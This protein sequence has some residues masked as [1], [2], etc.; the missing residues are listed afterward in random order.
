MSS[1]P[2]NAEPD[3]LQSDSDSL[4][5]ESGPVQPGLQST[6]ALDE[7]SAQQRL[8]DGAFFSA[9]ISA[10]LQVDHDR[11]GKYRLERTLGAG[12]QSMTFLA[13]DNDL[14][15]QVVLKVYHH[16]RT[17]E[18]KQVVLREGRMLAKVS[19]PNVVRCLAI[20][21]LPTAEFAK[22]SPNEASQLLDTSS[23]PV[24]VLEHVDGM[25][26]GQLLRRQRLTFEE[27]RRLIGKLADGLVAVH[28]EGLFHR[29]IKPGN[30]MIQ[31]MEPIFVDFGLALDAQ[32]K[33]EQPRSGTPAYMS[34]EQVVNT[35]AADSRSDIFSLGTV[36]YELLTGQSPFYAGT[37]TETLERV[38]MC[39][40]VPPEEINPKIPAD[41]LAV[42][43]KCLAANPNDRF[44]SAKSLR[45]EFSKPK[46][47]VPWT[48]LAC[49]VLAA[50]V[51]GT[52][53]AADRMPPKGLELP[54]Q[55]LSPPTPQAPRPSSSSSGIVIEGTEG[56][57]EFIAGT[58]GDDHIIAHSGNDSIYDLLGRNLVD[59]GPGTD[60][61]IVYGNDST[62]YKIYRLDSGNVVVEGP[63]LNDTTCR[64][65]LKDV[66]Q[67]NFEDGIMQVSEV[68]ERPQIGRPAKEI[69]IR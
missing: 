69:S 47:R 39:E 62:A 28:D 53:L 18:Q 38:R 50:A 67:I 35:I 27:V 15:R 26:L 11:A 40:F 68:G 22:I 14:Q 32:E 41:L 31:G 19:H 61:L 37:K 56:D 55:T 9:E 65:E 43:R 66:E 30:I 10:Q 57:D 60:T 4:S 59:G 29:D 5:P 1:T 64:N 24:L 2:L 12:G 52:F 49:V 42:C 8:M 58:E 13:F 33:S 45:Q 36:L 21:H 34:P 25:S 51:A 16:I 48:V 17:P 54:S 7:L 63:G 6:C 44:S 46:S 20:D 3:T 23:I